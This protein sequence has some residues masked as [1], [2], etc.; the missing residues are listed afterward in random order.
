MMA[1][2]ILALIPVLVVFIVFQKKLIE[3]IT[4]TGVTGG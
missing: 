3:G 4:F 2:V 1:G